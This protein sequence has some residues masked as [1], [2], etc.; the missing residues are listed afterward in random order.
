MFKEVFLQEAMQ[1]EFEMSM[2]G[3]LNFFLGLQVKQLDHG[4]FLN[5]SKYCKELLKKYEMDSCKESS[6]PMATSNYL[7][8]DESGKPF[9]STKYRGLIGS[10]L[11]L[12]A[13]RPDI[14]FSVCMC[15]RFQSN[16]KESHFAIAKRILKYL[17]GTINV[18]LWY[19]KGASFNLVGYSDADFAGCK[20]DRKSTSGTCHLLGSSLVSWHSKKQASVALSTAEAE[21]VAAGSCCA[22]T[23]WLKQQLFDYGLKL[24]HIPIRCDNTSAINLTKNPILHS[25]TKHIEIRHHFIRDHVQK[26]DC[27]IEFVDSN[28]QLADIFTKPLPKDRFFQLRNEL[29]VL[30]VSNVM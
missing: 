29:G 7:D 21:Y 26:G 28:N 24:D 13:S 3:D 25:R 1:G 4:T 9:D 14:M 22:Q 17:K 20:L 8:A 15:A 2:M 27:I 6:T 12:T 5:Q 11:Y 18:G 19:P 10:L 30:D 23:L 16:P